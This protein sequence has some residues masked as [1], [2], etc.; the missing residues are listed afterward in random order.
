MTSALPAIEAAEKKLDS[1]SA[2]VKEDG[3]VRGVQD[4]LSYQAVIPEVVFNNFASKLRRISKVHLESRL[5]T[6]N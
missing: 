1:E 3:I 4:L 2:A 6:L 5:T